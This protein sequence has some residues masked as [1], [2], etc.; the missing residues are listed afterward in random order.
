MNTPKVE[1]AIHTM[2]S[3]VFVCVPILGCIM[4]V[5]IFTK[6]WC[7]ICSG[8]VILN[9]PISRHPIFHPV[10]LR[11]R[12]F[13]NESDVP[14]FGTLTE[15]PT[16]SMLRAGLLRLPIT[17]RHSNVQVPVEVVLRNWDLDLVLCHV[18]QSTDMNFIH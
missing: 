1:V 12:I 18:V 4:F 6:I 10:L 15:A 7:G 3:I 13:Q 9:S 11:L 17:C 14:P 2:A 16:N 5:A 8:F